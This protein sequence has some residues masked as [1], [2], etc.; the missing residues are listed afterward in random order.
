[1]INL[2]CPDWR[3]RI[4]TGKS[5]I[6]AGLPI[7]QFERDL[8]VAFFDGLRLPD[9]PGMPLM[10]DAAGDWF[11]EIVGTLFGTLDRKTMR[12]CVEEIFVLVSKKNSKTTNG[13]ALMLVALLMNQRPRAEFLI[14][15]PT[16]AIA[17]LAF[18]QVTGM[19]EADAQLRRRFK[20]R[21]H[22]K[23]IKDLLNGAKLRVKTFD[24]NILTG[25]RPAGVLLDELHLLGRDVHASKVLRQIRGGRQ[26][27]PEGFLLILTTQSD[28]PPAGAFKEEL[29][30]ARNIRDG[31]LTGGV[32]L[33]VLYEFP[34]DITK[35]QPPGI[36]PL[37]FDPALWPMVMP[38]LGRSLRLDSLITD[39]NTERMKGDGPVS[40]WASQ[41]LDV[42]VGISLR[43]GSWPGINYWLAA[44][45]KRLTLV[46]IMERCE[47]CVVGIDGG[48]LDD[49]L[50]IAVLGREKQATIEVK[51]ADGKTKK[52]KRLFLWN[53]AWAHKDVFD[54]RKDIGSALE[55]FAKDKNLTIVE[56]VGDDVVAV[57]DIVEELQIRGLLPTERDGKT[58]PA[59]GVDQIGI[60]E[61]M[62]ELALR[63]IDPRQ[64]VGIPQ[65]YRLNGAI[66]TTERKLAGGELIH[67]GM[68]L[69]AWSVGNAKCEPRGNAITVT[70]QLSG[71]MKIDPLMATFDAMM[72]MG[73]N[74]DLGPSIYEERGLLV[75]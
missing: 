19:I 46:D 63:R 31:K 40:V 32:M 51:D 50:G 22:V 25:P 28:E 10:K 45:D 43:D 64:I 29:D 20:P 2:A 52:V 12:R 69:M 34:E 16:H 48:G 71:S 54:R 21:E 68:P 3:D 24:L 66:K 36:D 39:F 11:R 74:P 56:R 42:E 8:A 65:G 35:K 1:M 49:L 18:S 15:A 33:P 57:A 26:A 58:Y 17:D 41:H 23:E 47:L 72:V 7:D 13:A 30:T 55:G 62:D 37:W 5:L 27:T 9:V 14:V 53:H 67:C 4:R 61:I 44:G 75:L 70:K 6:P 60:S 73:A 59:I 38:N